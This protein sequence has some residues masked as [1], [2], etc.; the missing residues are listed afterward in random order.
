MN[1]SSVS[2][3]EQK[4][5][6][7]AQPGVRNGPEGLASVLPQQAGEKIDISRLLDAL[8]ATRP[9]DLALTVDDDSWTFAELRTF[10]LK[11]ASL[12]AARSVQPDQIVALP[13]ANSLEQTAFFDDANLKFGYTM[14]NLITL[15]TLSEIQKQILAG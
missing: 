5:A 12:L 8:A 4:A 14:R 2:A 13:M 9:S 3:P 15:E 11:A 7:R 10:A 1:K 6:M